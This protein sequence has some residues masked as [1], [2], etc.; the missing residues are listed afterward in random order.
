MFRIALACLALLAC[1]K[2]EPPA[3]LDLDRIRIVGEARM[4]TDTVGEAR[5][6]EQA[7]FV[8]VDAENAAEQGAY[9][10]L[11]GAFT[12]AAGTSL[13]ALKPQSLWI[14]PHEVRTFALVDAERKPR[15][16][17]TSAQIEVRGALIAAP[18][19]ARIVDLHTFDDRGKIVA[20]ASVANDSDRIGRVIVIASFHGKDGRP[21][22][23]PFSL[24]ELGPKQTRHVQFVGP[25]GS[26]RGTIYVGDETY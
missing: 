23:R 20:Q 19:R 1:A 12:D 13:G 25:E 4:R 7:S 18:P 10:T 2:R 15:P 24:V 6:A 9:V 26:V 5:F 3:H 22:T 17:A 8:L 11:G 14:P 21:M 16:G